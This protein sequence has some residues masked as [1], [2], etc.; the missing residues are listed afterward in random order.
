MEVDATDVNATGAFKPNAPGSFKPNATGSFKPNATGS[1][2][3]GATGT[4]KAAGATGAFKTSATGAHKVIKSAA[5][6][7]SLPS[8][9]SPAPTATSAVNKKSA[10]GNFPALP[11]KR[12]SEELIDEA[13]EVDLAE[14]GIRQLPKNGSLLSRLVGKL[15][16]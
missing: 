6:G 13:R 12:L 15:T 5:K 10:T 9:R 14:S 8:K 3:P 16:S 2:K 11:K 7:S 1:F 4:F